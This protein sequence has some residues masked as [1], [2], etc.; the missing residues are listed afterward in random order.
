MKKLSSKTISLLALLSLVFLFSLSLVTESKASTY[1]STESDYEF[2]PDGSGVRIT[3]YT[4]VTLQ[5]VA[6]ETYAVVIP[7]KLDGR[8][9]KSIAPYAFAEQKRISEFVIPK[10]VTTIGDHAFYNYFSVKFP[11]SPK[12]VFVGKI[13]HLG[14]WNLL[15]KRCAPVGVIS[16]LF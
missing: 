15:E 7:N 6:D 16:A 1:Q 9:V 8:T 13:S 3:K 4:G 5:Q 11:I 14:L 2:E 10:T 12:S